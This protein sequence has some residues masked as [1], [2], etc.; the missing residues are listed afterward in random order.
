MDL[1]S[2]IGPVVALGCIILGLLM[3]GGHLSSVL[4]ITAAL[5][6]LGG[7]AG[8][9]LVA[10][11]LPDV[12]RAMKSIGTWIK[13]PSANPE[14]IMKDIIDLAQTARKESILAL[15]KKRDSIDSKPLAT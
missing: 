8:S 6:V 3:E 11:P 1:T 5:I 7:M 2:L 9:I 14:Q 12:I 15:E 10:Y 4:Q 13:A